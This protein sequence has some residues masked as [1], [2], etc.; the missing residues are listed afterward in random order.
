M[1][2]TEHNHEETSENLNKIYILEHYPQLNLNY[3]R[4]DAPTIL[5]YYTRWSIFALNG[6]VRRSTCIKIHK[7][8]PKQ[9]N[10]TIATKCNKH[11]QNA[12]RACLVET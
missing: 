9:T 7:H 2:I 10:H 5:P 1:K 11:Q 3:H 6:Q 8:N 12:W 4:L